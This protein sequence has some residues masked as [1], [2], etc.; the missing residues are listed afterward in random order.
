MTKLRAIFPDDW[1]HIMNAYKK[2]VISSGAE[3]ASEKLLSNFV[4]IGVR[5]GERLAESE[6]RGFAEIGCGLAIPSLT[7]ARLG[8]KGGKAFDVDPK[9]LS[10]V[11]DLAQRLECD[12]DVECHDV[13][14]NRPKLEKGELLVAEKPA[15]YKKNILEVEYNLQNWCKIEGHNFALIP[16]FLKD[17]T[18]D[19]YAERCGR[20]ETRLRQVGF[21]VENR[22]VIAQLPYRWLIATKR[23]R[24]G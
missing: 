11:E 2:F 12:L 21:K 20:Y 22:Q 3:S 17:D 19:T 8:I 15:S 13:F 14:E 10:L 16:S 24:G 1:K 7:L 4:E 5:F 23:G 18:L 6:P 9:V